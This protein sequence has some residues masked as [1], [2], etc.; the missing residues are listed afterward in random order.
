MFS[1]LSLFSPLVNDDQLKSKTCHA[2]APDF[3]AMLC[4][5]DDL[6]GKVPGRE[7]LLPGAAGRLV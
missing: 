5:S 6:L 7:S 3:H 1:T 4:L 2:E